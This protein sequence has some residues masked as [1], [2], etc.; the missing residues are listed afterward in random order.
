MPCH[1]QKPLSGKQDTRPS[2][3]FSLLFHNNRG[4][5]LGVLD[6]DS[7]HVAVQLL[8]GTLLVVT[9]SGNADAKAVRDTLDTILPDLLVQL[10]VQT[11]VG[12]TL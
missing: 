5:T 1:T 6:V 9:A 8:L 4:Q 7:L 11:D 10:G 2:L 12:G 3:C